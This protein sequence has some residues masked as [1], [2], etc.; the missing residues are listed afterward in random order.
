MK[1]REKNRLEKQK[2]AIT[3][4]KLT[5]EVKDLQTRLKASN[6]RGIKNQMEVE[7]LKHKAK[8]FGSLEGFDFDINDATYEFMK[9]YEETSKFLLKHDFLTSERHS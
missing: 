7:K 3:I 8:N 5:K 4:E 1:N 6:H 9:D 2:D